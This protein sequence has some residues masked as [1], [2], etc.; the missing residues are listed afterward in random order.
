MSAEELSLMC[1]EDFEKQN[2]PLRLAFYK[3][4]KY[5][6]KGKFSSITNGIGETRTFR[7]FINEFIKNYKP[8]LISKENDLWLSLK[9]NGEFVVT[10]GE[11]GKATT[12]LSQ[13]DLFL[14]NLLCFLN[15]VRLWDE[16]NGIRDI[17]TIKVPIVIKLPDNCDFDLSYFNGKLKE[18]NREVIVSK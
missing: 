14:Y 13:K 15:L 11:S 12:D 7:A 3:D 16:F 1:F 17:N 9:E 2:Y 4:N 6:Y 10:K 18:M 8:E 5:F